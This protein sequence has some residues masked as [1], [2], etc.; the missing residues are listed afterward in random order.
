MSTRTQNPNVF[1][2]FLEKLKNYN[3]KELFFLELEAYLSWPFRSLPSFLGYITR[4]LVY[5]LLFKELKSFC[6]I[7]PNVFFSHCHN[8]RCGKNFIVNSHSYFHGL[9]GIEIGDYVLIGP[10]VVV[11]S[12]RHE[13]LGRKY[14]MLQ[15]ITPQKIVIGDGVWIGANAVIMPG[16]T[17]A[18]GTVVGAGAVVT[19]STQAFSVVVGVPAKR[20][21]TR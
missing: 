18:K 14:V 6:F 8:I 20:M 21:K 16:V 9:G 7:Q 12:G 13:I 4:F 19:K 15:N 17:L 11:S 10:N 1:Q 5:K 3:W 2:Y